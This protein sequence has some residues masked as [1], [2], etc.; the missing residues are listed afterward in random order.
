MIGDLDVFPCPTQYDIANGCLIHAKLCGK[1]FLSDTTSCV[2]LADFHD[3]RVGKF[4][5]WV[6][7]PMHWWTI[8]MAAAA[9]HIGNIVVISAD[10][11]MLRIYARSNITMMKD[12]QSWGDWPFNDVQESARRFPPFAEHPKSAVALFCYVPGPYPTSGDVVDL[13]LGHESLKQDRRIVRHCGLLRRHL[14]RE[15]RCL[16]APRLSFL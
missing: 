16:A 3:R 10:I 1:V 4:G 7:F 9:H 14:L 2:S 15:V 6:A 12:V 11:K 13:H 8:L 5:H